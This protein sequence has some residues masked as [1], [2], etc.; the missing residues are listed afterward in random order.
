VAVVVAVVMAMQLR[1]GG[2]G[3]F[4]VLGRSDLF[5]LLDRGVL[6]VS[7]IALDASQRRDGDG[8]QRQQQ[9]ESAGGRRHGP[10]CRRSGRAE[11][12]SR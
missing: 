3:E 4:S 11:K 12:Q 9:E 7:P 2:A 1:R 5:R 6:V 10:R 8:E